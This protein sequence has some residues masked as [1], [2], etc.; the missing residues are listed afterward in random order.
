MTVF[1]KPIQVESLLAAVFIAGLLWIFGSLA[2]NISFPESDYNFLGESKKVKL[3]PGQPVFQTFTA[4]DNNLNQIKII[5]GNQELK[6]GEK[7]VFEL[8]DESC[9]TTLA[10][11][12]LTP[13]TPDSHIY[14]RFNFPAQANS[15]GR[16]Y[17]FKA[18]YFS[19]RDRGNERPY[20]AATE[21]EQFR[22]HSYTNM[23][24]GR[25]YEGR[26]LKMRPA[27]GTGSLWSDLERLNARLSQYK[28]WFFKETWL[29][30]LTILTVL[31]SILLTA[32]LLFFPKEKK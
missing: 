27:Y 17:C 28:P 23:G 5:V 24:N 6:W 26:T 20:L 14:Y 22:D 1:R 32:L 30:S 4:I 10:S 18:T 25:T 13:L 9:A 21:E 2:A 31:G 3:D 29:T 19:P 7:I 16:Q 15:Q 8:Q 12:T 11:D